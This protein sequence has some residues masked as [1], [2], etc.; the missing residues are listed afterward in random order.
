MIKSISFIAILLFVLFTILHIWK[1]SLAIRA[2]IFLNS[3]KNLEKRVNLPNIYLY[4][5]GTLSLL[6]SIFLM[7]LS[8]FKTKLNEA[9]I[10][11]EFKTVDIIFVVDLSLSMNAIDVQPNRLKNFQDIATRILPNLKGNRIGIII[12]AGNSFSFCPLTSD[13]AAV[14]E[15]IDALGVEIVGKK[16]SDLALALQKTN[17]IIKKQNTLRKPIVVLVSD[18]EDHEVGSLETLNAEF[19]VWGFGT[20]EGGPI[21]YRDPNTAKGG[22]VTRFG[23]LSDSQ[24][25]DTIL[26]RL[27]EDRLIEIAK[28]QNGTYYN[29]SEGDNGIES[30]LTK[31]QY[32]EKEVR[33]VMEN[34]LKEEGAYPYLVFAV[35]LFFFE[36]IL[37]LFYS[38]KTKFFL[39]F[40]V[41]LFTHV[42]SIN[43][44]DLDT[45]GEAIKRGNHSF[46]NEQFN[47]SLEHYNSASPYFTDDPRL[48]FNKGNSNY[49]LKEYKESL[50]L[51]NK[52]LEN[53][54]ADSILKSKT[55]FN[56]GNALYRLGKKKEAFESYLNALSNNPEHLPSKN[57]LEYLRKKTKG[58]NNNESN[59]N[60]DSTPKKEQSDSKE[61]SLP[62]ST[63]DKIMDPFS[64]DSILKNKNQR[65]LI[66]NEKFW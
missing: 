17:Q 58:K 8:L 31:V 28:F 10:T 50:E 27:D 1:L 41:F 6:V 7:Y 33:E 29:M 9:E 65:S 3:Q 5:I 16:G 43:A 64:S 18:G 47:E 42:N 57:N 23:G 19:L 21:E 14:K 44:W 2:Q 61:K 13:I 32:S 48:S 66:D 60:T 34:L 30:L 12:F 62:K 55:Y 52:V 4:F 46:Q 26:T 51:Y 11:N 15:Y 22:F 35:L 53:P 24:T 37:S 40:C 54:N 59:P 63:A 49:K 25:E 56:K 39:F 38:R 36:R 45:G 20:L